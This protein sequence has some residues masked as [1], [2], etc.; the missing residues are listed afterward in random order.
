VFQ[1]I[2]KT[3]SWELQQTL[4][5]HVG[6]VT[7]LIFTNDG[8]QL[9]S[10]SS[11]RTVVVRDALER[12]EDGQ[13]WTIF[14]MKRT[15]KTKATPV[16]MALLTDRDDAL[17]VS[18]MD[19]NVQKWNLGTGHQ[20][21]SFKAGDGDG[22]DAV[23]LSSLIHLASVNG[24]N[25]LAGVSSTDKSLRLYN[26][27][28]S[29][30]GRDW[31]HTEG[32]TDLT[33][34]SSK[35]KPTSEETVEKSLV[36]VAVDGTVFIWSFGAREPQKHDLSQSMELMGVTPTKN[37]LS[38]KVPLR[39][40][41]SQSEMARFRQPSPEQEDNPTPTNP[42][43]RLQ[44]HTLGKKSSRFSLAQTPKLEPAPSSYDV[45]RRRSRLNRSPSPPSPNRRS[46]Q[47]APMRRKSYMDVS[48]RTSMAPVAPRPSRA[49]NSSL[50]PQDLA[51]GTDVICRALRSY[52]RKLA[53]TTDNLPSEKLRELEREL[54]ATVRAVGEKA[55]RAKDDF[56]EDMM[57]KVLNQYSEKLIDILQ[58]RMNGTRISENRGSQSSANSGA[59]S[60]EDEVAIET[61]EEAEE[62]S[63][64][65]E[66]APTPVQ[67]PQ[68][69]ERSLITERPLIPERK[70][71]T[72]RPPLPERSR[73]LRRSITP[74]TVKVEEKSRKSRGS[75]TPLSISEG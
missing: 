71:M 14:E 68:M 41:L 25:I 5:E 66:K 31:G 51:N 6:A 44:Q 72:E 59:S 20:M 39:R 35:A 49:S 70:S 67:S 18:T 65:E 50:P 52:R 15:K 24:S 74:Q 42:S 1:R 75:L 13:I 61:I 36:T 16:S 29:M 38:N 37:A 8:K 3:G 63:M 33:I 43:K 58:E 40:V 10:C 55:I 21:S 19:R 57:Q 47:H 54:T 62:K 17:F 69:S 32:I 4:D 46:P 22:G 34:I 27:N 11:D 30:L 64:I 60:A 56:N 9:L 2:N 26:E 23:I 7:G 48:N 45:P 12:E 73:S 28:G 53:S